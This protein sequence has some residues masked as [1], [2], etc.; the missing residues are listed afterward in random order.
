MLFTCGCAL[1]PVDFFVFVHDFAHTF[2]G[3]SA[4]KNA[5]SLSPKILLQLM[6]H[7][8]ERQHRIIL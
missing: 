4:Q 8:A 7:R 1:Q 5:R 3:V 2:G 6:I